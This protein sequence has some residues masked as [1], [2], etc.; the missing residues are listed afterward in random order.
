MDHFQ[1]NGETERAR[2]LGRKTKEE[3]NGSRDIPDMGKKSDIPGLLSGN[4]NNS[5][6]NEHV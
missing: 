5:N 2:G 3:S 6:N 1:K 4:N